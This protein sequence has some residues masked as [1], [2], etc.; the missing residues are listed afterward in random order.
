MEHV[1]TSDER[2]MSRA[3]EIAGRAQG[4]TSPNPAV[5]A[6]L[7][8]DGELLGEGFHEKAGEPH[9]EVMAFRNARED[10]T[11]ATLY[12]T[13]EPCA[14]HG[15]TPPCTEAVLAS[16]VTRVV[17]A[18][19]DPHPKVAGKGFRQLREAG[20]EVEVGVLREEA[21]RHHEAY[22]WRVRTGRAFGVLKAAVTLDGRLAADGGDSRWITGEEARRRA[23][24]LRD[25]Y[26]VVLVGRGTLDRDDPSLDVRLEAGGRDPVVVVLDSKLRGDTDRKLWRR[27]R[28]GATVLVATTSAADASQRAALEAQGVEILEL[29]SD[30]SGGVDL[31]ALFE[32]LAERG[33]NSVLVEGGERVHTSCLRSGVLGR[34]HVFV[35]PRILGG[36]DGPRLVGDLGN[37]KVAGAASLH[38]VRHEVLGSDVLISGRFARRTAPGAGEEN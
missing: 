21:E 17:A 29:P 30:F 3:L 31:V 24:E 15:R 11:G 22:L 26:D 28:A 6:V 2:W 4:R 32:R 16:G 18:L 8:R 38:D 36:T 12:V 23:H 20:L 33:W 5:G 1:S 7:V 10:V 13:L 9:A 37:R 14:F 35:A 34:A 19:E 27:A 25:V